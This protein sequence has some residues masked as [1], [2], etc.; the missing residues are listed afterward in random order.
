MKKL[1]GPFTQ[2]LP[3]S[4][5]PL[6][7]ALKDSQLQV[8]TN[9]SVLVNNGFIVTIGSFDKLRKDHPSAEIEEITGN[10]VLLPGFVDCHTHICYE[11]SG[12]DKFATRLQN[13]NQTPIEA[14]ANIWDTVTQ[15]RAASQDTLIQQLLQRIERH[16]ANG[17]TTMEIK[18]G[19]GLSVQDELKQLRAIKSAAA[20][21]KAQLVST[22]LLQKMP[23]DFES[24]QQ[25]YLKLI[26]EELL[27]EVKKDKLS[28][29]VDIVIEKQAFNPEKAAFFL[30][31]VKDMGFDITVHADQFTPG[32]SETAVNLGAISADHLEASKDRDIKYLAN[33]NVIAV[34]LPGASLGLGMGYAPAR[35][36][37][38]AGISLAIASDWNPVSA[39][40]GD[41]LMQASVLGIA[42]KLS[43]AEIFAGLTSRASQALKLRDCGVLSTG[44]R[45]DLQIFPCGD[46]RDILYNM[47]AMKPEVR[48]KA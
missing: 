37:L 7:G 19:Y 41:L 5:L 48:V 9:G 12:A 11:G 1:I 18:S 4:G 43:T 15:T 13:K 14:N 20:K 47:G 34:A 30:T 10:K 46:Y 27:Y 40:M 16:I 8:I 2:I 26:L 38:D 32:G 25:D 28:N 21:T 42:E 23:T 44:K 35:K 31:K 36:I 45:A 6:K 22:C 3:L 39:P 17:V 33:S 24:E 29:R